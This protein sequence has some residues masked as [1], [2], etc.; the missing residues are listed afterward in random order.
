MPNIMFMD[1]AKKKVF[2]EIRS[3]EKYCYHT[4]TDS[5]TYC[6]INGHPIFLGRSDFVTN[7]I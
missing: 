1:L 2:S 7:K 6:I 4:C 5:Y 3:D